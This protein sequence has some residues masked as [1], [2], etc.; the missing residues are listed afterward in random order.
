[1]TRRRAS[2]ARSLFIGVLGA[3]NYT[4]A[5]A[6]LTQR[7]HDWIGSHTRCLADLSGVPGAI[8]P[9]QLKTGVKN[10]CR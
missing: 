2:E 6:T 8:V 3:S 1:M 4:Y 9:D 5:E 7:V 10:A